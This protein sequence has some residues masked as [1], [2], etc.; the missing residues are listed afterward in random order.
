MESFEFDMFDY[1]DDLQ[2]GDDEYWDSSGIGAPAINA[3]QKRKREVAGTTKRAN[4]R[5][6]L[7]LEETGG[8]NVRFV[9]SAARNQMAVSQPP[10]LKKPAS[11]ALLPDWKERF[12]DDSGLLAT[13]TM[14]EDMKKAAEGQNED[15]P[16]KA[17]HF[18]ATAATEDDEEWEDEDEEAEE[19]Q[20]QLASLDP[21]TLKA[22]LKQKLGDAGLDGMDEGA[23][24]QTIAKMLSG[25]EGA[26]DAAGDLANSLLGQ[27]TQDD[28]AALSGWL[29]QQGVSLDAAEEEEDE[30]ASMATADVPDTAET[31][32]IQSIQVSPPD[33]AIEVL[34]RGGATSQMAIH[35]ASPST[36]AKK[37]MAPSEDQ[38]GAK[39]RKKVTFDVPTS[40]ESTQT[41][42]ED[43]LEENIENNEVADPLTSEDPLLSEPTIH[44]P[45]TS[46]AKTKTA[47][48]AAAKNNNDTSNGV[49]G[50][51][52]SKSKS[53]RQAQTKKD[54]EAPEEM[55]TNA[56]GPAKQSRKRKAESDEDEVENSAPVQK[57]QAR[58]VAAPAVP[59]VEPANKRTRSARAKA[60]K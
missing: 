49:T 7:S 47:N 32:A 35:G 24:M 43:G 16:P 44:E 33:S 4:K 15:T 41:A 18:D 57:K 22:V 13:K 27:A 17:R 46:A 40:S 23:F 25:D 45:R 26:E 5:R 42:A 21:E 9:S 58:K 28:N 1:W 30:T 56:S 6:K 3:S 14:P 11:F 51:A 37:R 53:A 12:A 52:K 38:E 31:N 29:S 36:S 19:L 20:A 10:V 54:A 8:D 50:P 55:K 34:N 59:N 39:K 60:G 48:A 2:Y